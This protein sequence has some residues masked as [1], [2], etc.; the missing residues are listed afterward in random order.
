MKRRGRSSIARVD[1][2][3]L[4]ASGNATQPTP[5]PAAQALSSRA[6]KKVFG[7][8]PNEFH[9]RLNH[10]PNSPVMSSFFTTPASQKKRKRASSSGQASKRGNTAKPTINAK[11]TTA[12]PS[13]AAR[14]ESISGSGSEDESPRQRSGSASPFPTSE[15]DSEDDE[16]AAEKRLR[17]AEQ[18]LEN[19]KG[20][21]DE[22]GFDAEEIDRDLIAE[23]LQEDVAETKGRLHKHIAEKLNFGAAMKTQFRGGRGLTVTGVATC[24][25]YVYTV[26]KDMYLVKWRLAEPLP[27]PS[28]MGRKKAKKLLRERD[29]A[30][31]DERGSKKKV[32]SQKPFRRRPLKLLSTHGQRNKTGSLGYMHHTAPILCVAASPSGQFV[33]TGGA[34]W[35][36]IIWNAADLKPLRVFTQHRD[37]V[38]SLTFRRGT[39]Q[40]FSASKDR[41]IKTWSL[42]ELAY[43]ETLFGHQDEVL[44]ICAGM[45]E[46]CVS[47]G[48]RDRTGRV[49]KVAEETQLVFR[50]GGGDWEKKRRSGKNGREVDDG[51]SEK[52]YA[53]GSIDRVALVDEETFVTGSD[54]GSI[55]LWSIHKKKPVFTV[56]LAHGLDPP[57]QPEEASAEMDPAKR[58]VPE[59]NP[60][61][62]TAL[63]TVI[64]SDLLVSGSW[65][66]ELRVW[67]IGEGRK[68][69][70]TLGYIGAGGEDGSG[71]AI[72][73][74]I[75]D[76]SIFE[77][78]KRGKETLGVVAAVGTE[79]RLGRW[80]QIK[81]GSK[82]A[83]LFEVPKFLEQ[84]SNKRRGKAEESQNKVKAT[85]TSR[86]GLNA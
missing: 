86:D 74:S 30:D 62:I 38:T 71:A 56:P 84:T 26:S 46:R 35:K 55:S 24:D 51:Q 2:R 4:E 3:S 43:V 36:L 15:E 12:K 76:L 81:D 73:G 41:T 52:S 22:A 16:T 44:D 69:L 28:T 19:I 53:E 40:L 11:S 58:I 77:R 48:G 7:A 20:T 49:W 13:V 83:V 85:L 78:G 80:K 1:G 37:A 79:G 67:K 10:S 54:N 65:D 23:R 27:A 33:A 18:Y 29:E 75:N 60:R 32:S 9:D 42:N 50:G 82:G 6:R 17:L 70:E 21:V 8:P 72:R 64:Y 59:P 39:N 45:G 68:S 61:W 34:D 47:V 63:A 5:I 66:G 31:R 25:P 57:L 14:D